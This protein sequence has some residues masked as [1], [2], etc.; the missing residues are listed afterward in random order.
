MKISK[1]IFN[2]KK[3]HDWMDQRSRIN[4]RLA[5]TVIPEEPNTPDSSNTSRNNTEPSKIIQSQI[6]EAQKRTRKL[7]SEIS[8]LPTGKISVNFDHRKVAGKMMENRDNP[9]EPPSPTAAHKI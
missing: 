7:K 4:P 3:I 8:V 1:N 6:L 2:Q 5:Q 9:D